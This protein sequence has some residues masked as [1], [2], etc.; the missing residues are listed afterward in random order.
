MIFDISYIV[1]SIR[2]SF[3]YCPYVLLVYDKMI[4][5]FYSGSFN[6]LLFCYSIILLFRYSIIITECIEEEKETKESVSLSSFSSYVVKEKEEASY[7]S[8]VLGLL[9]GYQERGGDLL[10]VLG[11]QGQHGRGDEY[12][13]WLMP[14][15][16]AG[17]QVVFE[18]TLA[19]HG[20]KVLLGTAVNHLP[21]TQL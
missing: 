21:H 17:I 15:H 8:F 12:S 6:I 3:V 13:P 11:Y 14:Q 16:P 19:K 7:L 5:M 9:L 10:F 4:I 1:Y 18:H 2:L 20:I